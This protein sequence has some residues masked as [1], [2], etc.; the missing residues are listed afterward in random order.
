[1]N[2]IAHA[3]PIPSP[4]AGGCPKAN[5]PAAFNEAALAPTASSRVR[6]DFISVIEQVAHR[7]SRSRR[8]E[9]P[10]HLVGVMLDG[11]R[12]LRA[13]GRAQGPSGVLFVETVCAVSRLGGRTARRPSWWALSASARR[14]REAGQAPVIGR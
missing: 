10:P 6:W 8:D 11:P 5:Q 12:D 3:R 4:A 13:R 1:V 9:L 2:H 7:G 14:C